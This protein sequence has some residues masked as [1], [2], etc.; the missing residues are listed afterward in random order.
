MEN[1]SFQP[2]VVKVA[3]GATVT[4]ANQDSA[5]HQVKSDAFNSEIMQK[6]QTFKFTFTQ[7]GTFNYLCSLHPTMT[8]TVIVE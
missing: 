6:G 4:W 1:F 8:G 3:V 2:H 7:A 5:P